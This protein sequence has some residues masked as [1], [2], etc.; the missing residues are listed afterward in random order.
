VGWR[1]LEELVGLEFG[2][3]KEQVEMAE[4]GLQ[5]LEFGQG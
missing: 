5:A 3:L 1:R 2:Q 4:Q